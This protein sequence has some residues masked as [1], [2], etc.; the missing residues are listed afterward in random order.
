MRALV[1]SAGLGTRFKSEKPKVMHNILG[2]PMLW[3]VL[4]TLRELNIE[5]TA[6]VVGHKAEQVK[7]YFGDSYHY[8][9]QSN[10]KGG[11]GDAVLSAIDFW[12]DYYGYMLVINGDSPLVKPQ[13]LKNMQRYLH[14][15]EEY[16]GIK[17]SALLLSTQLPD[18][19]GYGRIIKDGK[20]NVIKV[21]EEKDASF[22][23]K[24]IK[25]INGGVY[26]FYCPHLIETLFNV[27]PSPKTGELYLTEVFSLMH[28]KDYVVRSFMAEDPTE[29]LGANTRWELAVAENIIRLRILQEWAE[30]GNTIHQ[31]ESVW[32]EP[33]VVLEGD[34]EI[35]PDAMLRGNT[36]IGR[37]VIVGKGSLLE[38]ALVEEGVMIEAYSIVR[39]SHIKSGAIIGPFAHVRENSLIGKGSHIGNFVEVKKSFIGEGVRAKH[40]AYIGDATIEDDV[41]VGAGVVFANFDGKRKHQSYVGKGAFIGSNA[42]LIA[43]IRIGSYSFIA[44]GSVVN[45][46]VSDGD[47]AIE[48]SKLRI[49]KGKGKEKLLE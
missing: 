34:V 35:Y 11:T 24:L 47:L 43:P 15:V 28:E 30:K 44:G 13:T 40:L 3:Y 18:P 12:R 38:N 45:K 2:K 48:R 42:L 26:I 22:E 16:E 1:L 46:D 49:L 41:N 27:K 8:F 31:P 32:I 37:G 21:V 19:T 25:E 14:M 7:E 4:R 23:E 6:L 17:L 10:P 5:D 36:K 29:V 20:G 33:D 39:N 9:Y